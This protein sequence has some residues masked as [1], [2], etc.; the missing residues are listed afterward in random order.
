MAS[1]FQRIAGRVTTFTHT[2]VKQHETADRLA[3]IRQGKLPP[4]Y[5]V[6]VRTTRHYGGPEEGGWYFD[7]TDVIDVRRAFTFRSLLA[8]VR[9]LQAE[10]DTDQRGRHSVLG[11]QGDVTIYLTRNEH[12]IEGLQF[13]G[14]ADL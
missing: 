10:H 11:N 14:D 6:A 12:Q 4:M 3:E 2:Q 8:T 9:A 7:H 1:G 5:A 13:N